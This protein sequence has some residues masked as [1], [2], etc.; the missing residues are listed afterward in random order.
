MITRGQLNDMKQEELQELLGNDITAHKAMV[1]AEDMSS[2]TLD[3]EQIIEAINKY[4]GYLK[5]AQYELGD[6]RNPETN[7]II[8]F[9]DVAEKILNFLDR[10]EIEWQYTL[11]YSQLATFWA[12]TKADEVIPYGTFDTTIRTLG[13]LKYKGRQ[14]W[15]DIEFVNSYLSQ[16]HELYSRDMI[17][18]M[19][20]A[21][22]HNNIMDQM[23]KLE[24]A[25][26]TPVSGCECREGECAYGCGKCRHEDDCCCDG[27]CR[28]M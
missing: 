19:Y 27:E 24:D 12:N 14:D 9:R 7:K 17:Y 10:L 16:I 4:E 1:E 11:G 6:K 22:L 28:C 5:S 15:A 23:K 20:L 21:N 18:S 8:K 13:M 2:L 3:E 26:A 25:S